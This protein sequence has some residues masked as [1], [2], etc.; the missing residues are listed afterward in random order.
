MKFVVPQ[1]VNLIDEQ[2]LSRNI[3]SLVE[4]RYNTSWNK[5]IFVISQDIG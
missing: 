5:K 4:T 3:S 1:H 2:N